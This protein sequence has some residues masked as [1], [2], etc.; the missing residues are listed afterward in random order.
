MSILELLGLAKADAEVEVRAGGSATVR[1][2]VG[3]LQAMDP[4][5][6]RYL[7]AFAYVLSRTA[8]ADLSISA[9]ETRK[10]EELVTR[11]GDLAKEKARLVVEIAKSQ[12]LLFGGTADFVVTR[13]FKQI[14]TVTQ[15]TELLH[16]LFAVSAADDSISSAEE[17]E[18]R[19]IAREL[20]FC[21]RDYIAVR[22]EY[23]HLR[24]VMKGLPKGSPP[25]APG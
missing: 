25:A 5:Q 19:Q 7:A 11:F 16:C 18:V 24:E 14:S 12:A 13:E 22:S 3:E 17:E 15:R 21:H 9:T 10:M 4:E 20:G 8:H 1:R 2:I 6:A 23:N